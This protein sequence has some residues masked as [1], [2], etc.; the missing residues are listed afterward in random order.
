MSGPEK[1]IFVV[2][3]GRSGTGYLASL[4]SQLR[5]VHSSHEP[6]PNFADVMRQ[7]QRDPRLSE[8]FWISQKLPAVSS[9]RNPIY[10]ETSH[11]FCKGFFEPLV[12]LGHRPSIIFL[13]RNARE[14]AMSLCQM[15]TVPA[16]TRK[17]LHYLLQPDDPSC[18]PCEEWQSLSD[19]QLCYWYCLEIEKRQRV[20]ADVSDKLSLRCLDLSF[21]KM[22]N[23]REDGR[24]LSFLGIGEEQKL[25]RDDRVFRNA[26]NK[27]KQKL[28]VID[29]A[30]EEDEVRRRFLDITG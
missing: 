25:I 17:G 6:D 29:F 12:S 19:Y 3:T 2:T 1:M 26:K 8:E 11:L 5:G 14:V 9:V 23:G 13:R 18:S 24:L 30:F 10:L 21:A 7:A 22:V 16:R 20:Y 15:R 4:C 27:K 28:P